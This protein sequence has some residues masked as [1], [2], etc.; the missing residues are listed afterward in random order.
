[1]RHFAL[2]VLLSSIVKALKV[3]STIKPVEGIAH[4]RVAPFEG[5]VQELLYKR[6]LLG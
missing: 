3:F 1:M 2:E 6:F 5:E 4:E